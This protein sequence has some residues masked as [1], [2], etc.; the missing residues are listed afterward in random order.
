MF[1]P[2]VFANL[3]MQEGRRPSIQFEVAPMFSTSGGSEPPTNSSGIFMLHL[4]NVLQSNAEKDHKAMSKGKKSAAKLAHLLNAHSYEKEG[5]LSHLDNFRPY[6]RT[7]NLIVLVDETFN[8]APIHDHSWNLFVRTDFHFRSV[9]L[10]STQYLQISSPS[11]K[12]GDSIFGATSEP[13]FEHIEIITGVCIFNGSLLIN[14]ISDPKTGKIDVNQ[15]R[16]AKP[17]FHEMDYIARSSTAIAD[18]VATT[19]SRLQEQRSSRRVFIKLDV[20][21]WHY[22]H[23]AVKAFTQEDCNAAQALEWISAVDQRR[24]QIGQVFMGTIEDELQVRGIRDS[25]NYEINLSSTN[26]IAALVIKGALQ[27]GKSPSLE[28][29]LEKMDAEKDGCWRAF[30]QRVPTS[31]RP[32]D[33][34]Q[35]GF[36]YYVFEVVRPALMEVQTPVTVLLT[37]NK[38]NGTLP[39]RKSKTQSRPRRLIISIDD[40]AERRIYS[41]AQ[42]VL[43]KCRQSVSIADAMLVEVYICRKALVNGNMNRARLY[44][45]DP[46]PEVPMHSNHSSEDVLPLDLVRYLYGSEYAHDLQRRVSHAG[47]EV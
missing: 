27:E 5:V 44:H 9:A 4:D 21:S 12:D 38:R 23:S 32:K 39:P 8:S 16:N 30:Y 17:T 41:Q 3:R 34:E 46:M 13:L 40:P 22:Y 2:L 26:N 28:R 35:L 31:Q 47:L 6:L 45:H 25:S 33:L 43:R 7:G 36:L 19:V 37:E 15:L 42:E 11:L 20:P 1:A 14:S 29:I 18:V 10:T 24:D